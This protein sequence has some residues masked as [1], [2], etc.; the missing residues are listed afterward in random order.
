[1]SQINTISLTG[2]L[3]MGGSKPIIKEKTITANGT[4]TATSEDADGYSPVNVN[5]PERVPVVIPLTATENGTY[6]VGGS[7]DGYNP[8]VVDVPS[9]VLCNV[10]TNNTQFATNQDY[11]LND[12]PLDSNL[13][14]GKK[15]LFIYNW[16]SVPYI[17]TMENSEVVLNL[18]YDSEIK[19]TLT[20]IGCDYYS[21]NYR[22]GYAS[23]Y[24][25]DDAL[26]NYLYQYR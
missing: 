24:E 19:I 12:Q 18:A 1:M 10:K 26:Y 13:E 16:G 14:N 4:Y 5:V 9:G 23:I 3:T 6:Q 25:I 8:V 20:T 15:Y 2:S 17:F 7:V 11:Y 21:G 22:N